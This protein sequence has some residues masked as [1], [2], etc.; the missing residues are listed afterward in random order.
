MFDENSVD[1]VEISV[2]FVK[3]EFDINFVVLMKEE[4]VKFLREVMGIYISIFKIEF[5]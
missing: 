5:I 4:G 2:S 1:E 3:D